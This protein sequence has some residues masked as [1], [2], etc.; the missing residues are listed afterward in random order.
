LH[1]AIEK[2][3]AKNPAALTNVANTWLLCALAEHDSAS[4]SAALA[5]LGDSTF[6]DNATQFNAKFG[7]GLVA[8]MTHDDAKARAIFLA[9]R[10]EQ[11]KRVQAQPHF[12]PPVVILGLIDAALGR[13]DD[14]LRE[15]R[16]AAE[17][18]PVSK[19]ATNGAE[20]LQ[21]VAIIAAWVG[22]KDLALEQLVKANPSQGYGLSY[23]RLKLLPW[24][25]PLR[26]D[27]RFEKIVES[28][29][30]KDH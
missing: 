12:G 21:Y 22:D 13:K 10:E 27:P 24:Y 16:Q 23:G 29:A 8:R 26:G 17:L 25:D 28:I 3:R 15:G 30:P 1:L 5:A 11:A 4:S 6:G 14:A 18:T 7:E 19:D 2:I 9:A 20:I